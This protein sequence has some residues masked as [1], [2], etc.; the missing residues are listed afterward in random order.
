MAYFNNQQPYFKEEMMKS[1]DRLQ[2]WSQNL[3]VSL[4]T[5]VITGE[6]LHFSKAQLPHMQI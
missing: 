5:W 2:P 6:T 3:F 4:F 1:L